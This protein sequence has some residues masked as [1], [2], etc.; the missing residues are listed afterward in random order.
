MNRPGMS[1]QEVLNIFTK[2][3]KTATRQH[4][5]Q[6]YVE[7]VQTCLCEI[8]RNQN[9]LEEFSR[10]DT[11]FEC[12]CYLLKHLQTIEQDQEPKDQE[13]PTSS[14]LQNY[15]GFDAYELIIKTVTS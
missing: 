9:W 5:L 11:D 3:Q 6:R 1:F 4:L 2:S 12:V 15:Q 8:Y 7:L 10:M 13:K 14:E